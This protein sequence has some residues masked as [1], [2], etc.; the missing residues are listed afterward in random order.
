MKQKTKL[1]TLISSFCLVLAL[2]IVGVLAVSDLTFNMGGSVSFTAEGVN[3]LIHDAVF[4]GITPSDG[5][6]FKSFEVTTNS[7]EPSEGYATWGRSGITY[8]LGSTGQGSVTIPIENT[9]TNN[10]TIKVEVTITGST[11]ALTIEANNESASIEAGDDY[12]IVITFATDGIEVN[13]STNFNVAIKLSLDKEDIYDTTQAGSVWSATITGNNASV[14]YIGSESNVVIPS[15][16]KTPSGIFDVT[17][18]AE[19]AFC[20]ND[21]LLGEII[22]P[23]HITEI[24]VAA[25]DGVDSEGLTIIVKG[26]PVIRESAFSHLNNNNSYEDGGI[27]VVFEGDAYLESFAFSMGPSYPSKVI[28]RGNLTGDIHFEQAGEILIESED[29][30]K[31]N[32][33]V[34]SIYNLNSISTPVV[35][36]LREIAQYATF[37]NDQGYILQQD[38]TYENEL[39]YRYAE[40]WVGENE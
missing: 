22:I 30:L 5:T 20:G 39:Y 17:A 9:S 36:I 40:V 33:I 3:A 7:A 38:Q 23:E 11:E 2:G 8:A 10:E 35:Y 34:A 1:I 28:I 4:D 16:V 27:I 18:L 14:R 21:N 37:P 25:F 32:P 15:K 26:S 13:A 29:F 12:E 24:G 19:N 6:A 31:S